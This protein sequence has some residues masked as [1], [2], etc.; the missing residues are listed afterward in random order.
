MLWFIIKILM[1]PL[2]NQ[3]NLQKAITIQE[4]NGNPYSH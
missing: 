1:K 2:R 3:F 4:L